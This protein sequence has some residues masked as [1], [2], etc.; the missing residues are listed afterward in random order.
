MNVLREE[1]R[2]EILDICGQMPQ[3]GNGGRETASLPWT[4][5][6]N[7]N[8]TGNLNENPCEF[9]RRVEDYMEL[10]KAIPN[11]L[12]TKFVQQLLRGSAASWLLAINPF[13]RNF[14]DFKNRFLERYWGEQVRYDFERRVM[15]GRWEERAGVSLLDYAVDKIAALKLC[16]PQISDTR[17]IWMITSHFPYQIQNLL[18]SVDSLDLEKMQLLLAKYDR[19]R[20]GQGSGGG[21]PNNQYRQNE[22]QGRGGPPAHQATNRGP[23]AAAP[24][25]RAPEGRQN[26]MQAN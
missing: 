3:Q 25:D 26:Q 18:N 12:K 9:I 17:L 10:T 13:P 5:P 16:D 20:M 19:T 15:E 11:H 1:M 21:R 7:L 23:P 24:R 22:S 6:S 8:F 4:P 14:T 2:Q